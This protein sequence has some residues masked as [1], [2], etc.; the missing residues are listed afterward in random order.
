MKAYRETTQWNVEHRA[1]NHVYLMDGD[2]AHAYIPYG[3]KEVKWFSK[4][5]RLDRRGRKFAEVDATVFGRKR[6]PEIKLIKVEGSKGSVYYVDPDAG[7][8]TCPGYTFRG[9]CRHVK[10]V[11]DN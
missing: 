4:P 8:C 1:P 3:T 10:E 7:S 11:L 2:W 6:E 5:L 9:N